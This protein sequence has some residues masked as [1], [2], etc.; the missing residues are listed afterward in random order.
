MQV[1]W[2]K[3]VRAE[4]FSFQW[5]L[6]DGMPRASNKDASIND[7]APTT[8]GL[9]TKLFLTQSSSV[10]VG[11]SESTVTAPEPPLVVGAY[12]NP[13]MKA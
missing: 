8:S 4:F 2:R 7:I 11:P 13:M 6:V 9:P 12:T 5:T 1:R 10:T 3:D